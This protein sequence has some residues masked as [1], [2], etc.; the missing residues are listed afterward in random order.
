M[1]PDLYDKIADAE[2]HALDK[3]LG[4]VDPDEL[5]VDLSQGVLTLELADGEKIIINSHRAAGEIWM[6]AFRKAWHF[7]PAQEDGKWVWRTADAELRS[8]LRDV[9]RGK[10]GHPVSL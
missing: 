10:L 4:E 9:L 3:A 1:D 8:T 6:A 2:L 5:D 7:G